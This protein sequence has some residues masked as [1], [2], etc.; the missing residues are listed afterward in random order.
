MFSISLVN[1]TLTL[2][3]VSKMPIECCA[4]VIAFYQGNLVLVE[5]FSDPKGLALPGGRLDLGESLEQCAIREFREE[6]GLE[7][8]L[9]YQFRTYSAVGRDPRGQ[10]VST[11]Y[12]GEAEGEYRNEPG[13]T[14]VAFMD[15]VQLDR[16]RERFA[17]DHYQILKEYC[18][19]KESVT[20]ELPVVSRY[21]T[22]VDSR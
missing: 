16:Y 8:V 5:R 7:L 10:K 21:M 18:A 20:S 15:L 1:L 22:E 12:I 11:V 17:F 4:D 2:T 3:G 6:T 13:K 9:R 14:K 19:A